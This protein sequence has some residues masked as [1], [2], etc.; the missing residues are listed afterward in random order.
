[1]KASIL[2]FGFEHFL[3]N[4][5]SDFKPFQNVL[6]LFFIEFIAKR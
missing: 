2:L 5:E 1:M 3:F 4:S 6:G